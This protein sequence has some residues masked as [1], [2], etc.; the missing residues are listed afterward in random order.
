MSSTCSPGAGR[1][2]S[3]HWPRSR[4]GAHDRPLSRSATIIRQNAEKT[5]LSDRA[6][7]M[8]SD[9][10]EY[11]RSSKGRC[12]FDFVFLDPPY[13]SGL[14]HDSLAMLSDGKLLNDGAWIFAEDEKNDPFAGDDDLAAKYEVVKECGYGR[15]HITVLKLKG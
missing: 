13:G 9:A 1:W 3:R 15:V 12:K 6:S 4:E 7:V 8:T 10:A 11:I 2:G 5:H 14:L